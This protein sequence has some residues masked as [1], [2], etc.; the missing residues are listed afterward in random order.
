MNFF[1][2]VTTNNIVVMGRKTYI[3][4]NQPLKNRV[5]VIVSSSISQHF[6]E[7]KKI[8]EYETDVIVLKSFVLGDYF[9]KSS[10][11]IYII[12]GRSIY[13]QSL[14]NC[15]PER[16]LLSKIDDEYEGNEYFPEIP[17]SYSFKQCFRISPR[18]MVEEWRLNETK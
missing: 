11:D 3:S 4:L 10:K 6:D 17:N 7:T 16:L 1:K 14:E 9:L 13:K 18:L 8:E 12:G 15:I 5:N 2:T